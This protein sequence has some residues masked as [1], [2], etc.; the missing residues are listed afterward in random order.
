MSSNKLTNLSPIIGI[1][2]LITGVILIAGYFT[3]P[4]S[5]KPINLYSGSGFALFGL[6][7]CYGGKLLKRGD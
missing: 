2:F 1:F 4:A 5:A 7:M 3:D 6:L